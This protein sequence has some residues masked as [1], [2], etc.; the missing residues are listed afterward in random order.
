MIAKVQL[1]LITGSWLLALLAL[2]SVAVLVGG[3]MAEQT[4]RVGLLKAVGGTP[5]LVAVVLLFEHVLV[6]LCAAG[7]GL[8]AGWL[9]APLLDGP[10]AGLLGAP[11]APSLSGSTVGLVIALALGGGGRWRR[12]CR[13]SAPRARARSPRSRTR[14]GRRGAGQR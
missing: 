3:R 12:S 13:P 14:P 11:S 10:G 2:A 9:A 7:V 8:V 1:V 4:R 6:G 5:R